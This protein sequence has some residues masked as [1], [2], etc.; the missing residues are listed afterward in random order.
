MLVTRFLIPLLLLMKHQLKSVVNT[1]YSPLSILNALIPSHQYTL[2]KDIAYGDLARQKLD[3]YVPKKVKKNTSVVIFYYGGGWDSG[4]KKD[5]KFAAEAFTSNGSIV[6]IP[7]YRVYPDVVF[8]AFM[9]DP[10]SAAKWV[11]SQIA[12]Y[13]GDANSVFLAGHSAGAHLAVMMGVNPHYLAKEHMAPLDF[14]GVIGLAGPYDFLPLRSARL[15]EIFGPEHARWQSQPIHFVDGKN[16]SMLLLVGLKDDTVW[17]QN[18]LNLA[19]KI[20]AFG[21]RVQ[22]ATF[23]RYNHVDMAAKLS[24]PLRGDGAMLASIV[25]FI[26]QNS[27]HQQ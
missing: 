1:I 24:K 13:G 18:T 15:K 17:P 7:D 8:P 27:N 20:N 11:K 3:I 22:V 21:G 12:N 10:V 16:P 9:Q 14:A 23:E 2:F 26:K 4:R 25:T 6:V 19:E 5:Y